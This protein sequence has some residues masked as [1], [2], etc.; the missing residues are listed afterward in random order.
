MKVVTSGSAFL[1]I[2]AYGGMVAYA[3]LLR[4]QGYNAKAISTAPLNESITETVQFWNAEFSTEYDPN[5]NDT[6]SLIDVSDPNFFDPIVDLNKVEEVIDHHTGFEKY[7]RKQIG[8]NAKIEFIGAACTLVFE[9]WHA[10]SLL[11]K[12]STSSA[13]LLATGILDNTLNFKAG[14]TTDRDREAYDRLMLPSGLPDNWPA[15][16]FGECQDAI[17][18]DLET[19]LRNDTKTDMSPNLPKTVGQLVV[20]DAARLL[21][22]ES[23]KIAKVLAQSS[24]DWMINLVSIGEDKSYFMASGEAINPDLE[25]ILDVKFE[26]GLATAGHMILRKEILKAAQA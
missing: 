24:P 17:E 2:D 25:R 5:P 11:G 3:E 20:W 14:V 13:K 18:A 21:S 8:K 26:D 4:E 6:F 12:M 16:Y 19:A 10:T 7:W 1:D 15:Q 22:D 23:A 9:R